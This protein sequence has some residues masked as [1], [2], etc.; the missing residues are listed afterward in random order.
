MIRIYEN[1]ISKLGNI[2]FPHKTVD[3]VGC[4]NVYRDW[5]HPEFPNAE[6]LFMRECDNYFVH[7]WFTTLVF[8]NLKRVYL[9]SDTHPAYIFLR[10]EKIKIYLNKKFWHRTYIFP[11]SKISNVSPISS[12]EISK[13]LNSYNDIDEILSDDDLF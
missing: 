7:D 8:P 5:P 6:T 12:M 1:M 3:L 2:R 11:L 10:D 9:D 13:L 4:H